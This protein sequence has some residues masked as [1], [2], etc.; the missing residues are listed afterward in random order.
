[1]WASGLS[2]S[3]KSP[4]KIDSD[5]SNWEPGVATA[6]WLDGW[7]G[8]G[9]GACAIAVPF[10]PVT[11]LNDLNLEL[12]LLQMHSCGEGGVATSLVKGLL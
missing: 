4:F 6:C 8:G 12:V 9:G 11:V 1:M 2:C 5:A 7:V 3:P 10:C